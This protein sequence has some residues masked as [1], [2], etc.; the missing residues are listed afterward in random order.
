MI[1]IENYTS[2]FETAQEQKEDPKYIN[3]LHAELS[4][5]E[6]GSRLKQL[7][8]MLRNANSL[9]N[10]DECEESMQK[11]FQDVYETITAPGL[12]DFLGWLE[13][14]SGVSTKPFRNFLMNG[15]Y[16]RY[17]DVIDEIIS[18]KDQYQINEGNLL[19]EDLIVNFDKKLKSDIKSFLDEKNYEHE[20]KGF[21][22][23]IQQEVCGFVG[24][25]ELAFT[26]KSQLLTNEQ[27]QKDV[28]F[29]D[30]AFDEVIDDCQTKYAFEGEKGLPLFEVVKRRV[31][32]AR[33][34]LGLLIDSDIAEETDEDIKYLFE[35]FQKKMI[36]SK[37][38]VYVSLKAY[39]EQDWGRL[40]NNYR[41]IKAFQGQPK[42]SLNP[43]VWAS[44]EIASAIDAWVKKYQKLKEDDA[45]SRLR[46]WNDDEITE[47]LR[48]LASDIQNWKEQET[49]VREEIR[50]FF[51]GFFENYKNKEPMLRKIVASNH[52]LHHYCEE[53][54]GS[55]GCLGVIKSGMDGRLAG[56]GELLSALDDTLPTMIEEMEAI[57]RKYEEAMKQ[58]GLNQEIE[59]LN[60]QDVD[61]RLT[62]ENF[63][64]E[65][66]RKLLENQMISITFKREY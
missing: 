29:Y 43:G 17:G 35:R 55:E 4:K 38:N 27:K 22:E 45:F 3:R 48:K 46:T 20:V 62:I 40:M 33:K 39:L 64:V 47:K 42:C 34:S 24:I 12:D 7:D 60:Q 54:Y 52:T 66:L 63:D 56:D 50:D 8:E 30:K 13:Q 32:M 15:M 10:F 51:D 61:G 9:K 36:R 18:A 49:K 16:E 28:A 6:W 58:S 26:D 5:P 11:L 31:E 57:K 37:T 41:E 14:M 65:K 1:V 2:K 21:L 44:L 25:Q 23:R 53:I 19:F 59:W